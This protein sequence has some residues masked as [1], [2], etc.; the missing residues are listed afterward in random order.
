[1]LQ[2]QEMKNTTSP[3]PYED[4]FFDPCGFFEF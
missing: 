4:V 3:L 1:M 2:I